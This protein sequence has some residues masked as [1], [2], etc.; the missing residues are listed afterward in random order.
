[1]S[2]WEKTYPVWATH[3][4]TLLTLLDFK[5]ISSESFKQKDEMAQHQENWNDVRLLSITYKTRQ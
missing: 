3:E 2:N 5:D 4:Y 1:M